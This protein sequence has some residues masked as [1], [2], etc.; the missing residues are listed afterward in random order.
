MTTD[1]QGNSLSGAT[2]EAAE[3]FDEAVEAFNIY[4]GDPVALLDNAIKAAPDF[5]MAHIL[6]AH[7]FGLATEPDA[8][9]EAKAILCKAK[10]LRLSDREVSHVAALDLVT[11][12]HWTAAATALDRHNARYPHDLVALQSGHLMDFFR[13]SA[14]GLR[15]RIARVL[16]KWSPDMPGYSILLGMHAFGLEEAGDYA[17]AEEM[18]RRAVDLQPLDCWAHHAVAHVMEMQGRAEDGIGWM[19]ARE[20]HWSGDDNFFKVHNWWHRSLY[21]LDLGQVDEVFALYDGPIRESRSTLAIDMVD[22][23]ALLW[24]L[25]LSGHDVGERWRELATTWENHADGRTYP[26]NDWHAVMAYL[27]TGRQ[28]DVERIVRA[29]RENRADGSDAAEWGRRT[30]VPL[31]EGFV[32]FWRGDYQAAADHLYG[33]RYIANSFG[34]SHA[35]RDIVD[36]TLTEAAIRGGLTGLAEALANERLALKPHSPVNRTFLARAGVSATPGLKAA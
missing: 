13:A 16:P 30:A 10:T 6:K 2:V 25:H 35:Q 8:T 31:I 28:S 15:D 11:E 20:P 19:I 14:R 24:R 3:F 27:G 9:S 23:S 21:H 17:R 18:G 12:G 32:A 1:K 26:F 5:A 22:A 29:Y 36:W 4:R 7:L 33:A 34:G